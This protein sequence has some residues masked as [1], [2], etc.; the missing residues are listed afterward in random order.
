MEKY[1]VVVSPIMEGEE[2]EATLRYRASVTEVPGAQVIADTREEA[3]AQLEEELAA[4]LDNIEEQ[5]GEVPAPLLTEAFD[6]QIALKVSPELHRDLATLARDAELELDALLIEVMTRAVSGA[7]RGGRRGGGRHQGGG[8]RQR[9]G[10]PDGQ[11]YHD[12]MEDRASF[13]QYV[14]EQGNDGGG[15]GGGGRGGRGRGRR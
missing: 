15:G 7:H 5:G 6:G 9:R 14:R 4:Q 3:L 13:I 10:G 1:R 8:R 12:I 11:R 2:D